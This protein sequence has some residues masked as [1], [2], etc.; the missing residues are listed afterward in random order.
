MS[1]TPAEAG[2]D[3]PDSSRAVLRALAANGPTTRPQLGEALSLSKPTMSAAIAE[4]T[5][6][7]LVTSRGSARGA[8]G[9]SAMLYC[10]APSAGHVLGV[11]AGATRVRVWAHALDGS[12]ITTAEERPARQRRNVTATVVS[13]AVRLTEQVREAV[14]KAHGP[15]RDVVIA[16]PTRPGELRPESLR[17]DGVQRLDTAL[18]LPDGTPAVI[19]NNVNCAA[20]AEHRIG[21]AQGQDTFVYLQVGVKI[22]LGVVVNGRLLHGAHGATGE[23]ARLPFPWTPTEE[24][25]R[26]ALEDYLGS[27]A[28]MARCR[29]IW[30]PEHGAPPRDAEELFRTALGGNE[31]ARRLVDRHGSDIGRLVVS[32]LCVLDPQQVVLG[33]GVG[34]NQLLLPE[35]RRTVRRLAWDTEITIGALGD[36]ATVQGAVHLAIDRSLSRIV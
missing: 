18:P 1:Q 10:V 20:V 14:G 8:T 30:P 16:A 7:G 34:Q 32:V 23:V 31:A 36:Y 24:P 33:G 12:Q 2:Y 28:L 15:L 9:R 25:E 6:H 3:L 11:E 27:A 21:A 26:E 35:V 17:P 22:G 19:E 4:L 5:A 29:E 13:T